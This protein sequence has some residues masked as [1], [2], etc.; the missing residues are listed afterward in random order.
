M[1]SEVSRVLKER[2]KYIIISSEK[3]E[4]RLEYLDKV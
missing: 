1:L 4:F 2:G 3:K